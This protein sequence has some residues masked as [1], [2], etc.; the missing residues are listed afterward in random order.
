MVQYNHNEHYA[1]LL[2]RQAPL[3]CQNALDIGCGNGSF[4]RR[5]ADR[6]DSA[7]TGID[8]DQTI[9]EQAQVETFHPRVQFVKAGL[10]LR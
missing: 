10:S 9:I 6:F 3:H 4:A 5:L 8:S 2:L 7:V 1:D